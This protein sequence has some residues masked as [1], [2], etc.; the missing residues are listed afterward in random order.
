M[1]RKQ[2]R[3]MDAYSSVDKGTTLFICGTVVVFCVIL[4]IVTSIASVVAGT[5][6]V[7]VISV[8]TAP[9][10]IVERHKRG[11]YSHTYEYDAVRYELVLRKD[12]GTE[13]QET[14]VVKNNDYEGPW[15]E[16]MFQIGNVLEYNNFEG[17]NYRYGIK[18]IE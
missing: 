12:D 16:T 15:A 11:A 5:T 14:M 8:Q 4:F 10:T 3:M 2:R 9:D 7:T 13:I 17:F 1:T 18:L 6:K